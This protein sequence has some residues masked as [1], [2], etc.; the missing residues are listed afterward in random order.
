MSSYLTLFSTT[1][2]PTSSP[3]SCHPRLP[4]G[5]GIHRNGSVWSS[6]PPPTVIHVAE[7]SS[8]NSHTSPIAHSF[9]SGSTGKLFVTPCLST[10]HREHVSL[11]TWPRW[12]SFCCTS[13]HLL[14]CMFMHNVHIPFYAHGY[15]L[16]PALG[17]KAQEG[18]FYFFGSCC[19]FSAGKNTCCSIHFCAE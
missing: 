13:Y 4:T 19:I 6:T 5:P 17:C 7:H 3:S 14:H 16:L 10:I 11:V 18:D 15:C 12:I 9:Q 1:S 2:H 8:P